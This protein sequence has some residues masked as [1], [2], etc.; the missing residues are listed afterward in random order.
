LFSFFQISLLNFRVGSAYWSS[1]IYRNKA[2]EP[3]EEH[4]Y[5]VMHSWH[6]WDPNRQLYSC[7]VHKK[8]VT[9][10]REFTERRAAPPAVQNKLLLLLDRSAG[11][12]NPAYRTAT[13]GCATW[14]PQVQC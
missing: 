9:G 2:L 5:S 10:C 13:G 11:H 6:T 1:P 4:V 3:S 8:Q 7:T 14:G 12:C